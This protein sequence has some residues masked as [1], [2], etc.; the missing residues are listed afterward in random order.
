[1][2]QAPRAEATTGRNLST[3]RH[4][5]GLQAAEHAHQLTQILA[6]VPQ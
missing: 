6:Q 2:K 5:N 3:L 4:G 1:M